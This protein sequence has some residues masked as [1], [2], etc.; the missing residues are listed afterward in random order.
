MI[1]VAIAD[2]HPLVLEAMRALV[3]GEDDMRVVGT[4]IDGQAVL[5]RIDVL[6]PDVLVLDLSL[7]GVTGYEVLGR[8][9]AEVPEV[10]V[11]VYTMYPES[12]VRRGVLAAGASAWL[13]KRRPPG[14][15]LT[16]IRAVADGEVETPIHTEDEPLAP[17]ETLS[18]RQQEVLM[19]LCEGA[20]PG[21]MV[22]RLDLS[23]STVSSHL[24]AIRKKL[25]VETNGEVLLYAMTM[26][27]VTR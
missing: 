5:D 10:K 7:P 15:L 2:D 1:R 26:G 13:C 24:M 27:L 21:D 3:D 20:D 8:L 4:M 23:P 6:I 11:L 9:R 19:L 12:L 18:P 17:H 22:R 25:G 14:E 16:L